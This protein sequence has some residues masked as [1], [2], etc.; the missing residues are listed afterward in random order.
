MIWCWGAES[1]NWK[2]GTGNWFGGRDS[3][4]TPQIAPQ[5]NFPRAAQ[6][7]PMIYR[8]A[9]V[10]QKA[11]RLAELACREA[12]RMPVRER[13]TMGNQITR[14]AVSVASNIAEGWAR[15]SRKEKAHFLSIAQGSLD[16]LDTQLLLS[17][18]LGW[19]AREAAPELQALQGQVGRMLTVLRRK[20]RQPRPQR[21]V[22]SS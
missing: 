22:S 4:L 15:E 6:R 11:M 8:Q 19:I 17:L 13:I 21:P 16:E 9:V 12:A 10:W 2:L 5:A 3:D 7:I 14:A 18:R 1:R 20:L